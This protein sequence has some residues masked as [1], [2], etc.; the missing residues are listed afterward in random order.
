MARYREIASALRGAITAGEYLPGM[1]LP[2]ITVLASQW[3]M[4]KNTVSAAIALLEA[5]GLVHASPRSGI[6]V[7]DRRP[8]PVRLSR[9]SSVMRPGGDLG[10]WETA[11]QQAGIPGRMHL[12]EAEPTQAAPDVAAKLGLPPAGRR[13][14]RRSRQ[15]MLGD[16]E[17][18]VQLHTSWIPA[19]I[20][21]DTPI[22]KDAKIE[23]GIY[24]VFV[25]A[26]ITPATAA[27][28]VGARPATDEET[29]ELRIRGGTV[30]T[31]ERLTRDTDGR[32]I[33]LLQIV[34]DPARS[35]LV[36]DPLPLH[37]S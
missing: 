12:V 33:E 14:W 23:G 16:P 36:Y 22:A 29:A 10:P 19:R 21:R 11:C 2:P 35:V 25:A 4:G 1:Q 20:A 32:A 28:T 24:G 5:E 26:G 8:V 18:V 17:R 7:L 13:V 27:E 30:L 9:Y 6:V 3:G 31:V 37:A 15:A 34:A